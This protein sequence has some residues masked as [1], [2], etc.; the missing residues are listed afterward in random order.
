MGRGRK[1][2]GG[3]VRTWFGCQGCMGTEISGAFFSKAGGVDPSQC[4]LRVTNL[5]STN[6]YQPDAI[7]HARGRP[8]SNPFTL[9]TRLDIPMAG[10]ALTPPRRRHDVRWHGNPTPN[11]T[12]RHVHGKNTTHTHTR[13]EMRGDGVPPNLINYNLAVRALGKGGD[14]ERATGL[15]NDMKKAG[16]S[17]DGRTFNAA[18]EVGGGNNTK[19]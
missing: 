17:P 19:Q 14:W 3:E 10:L 13:Q 8:N 1:E 9:S 11:H 18:I 6:E 2:P 4:L 15:L 12:T 16:V 5:G 7:R